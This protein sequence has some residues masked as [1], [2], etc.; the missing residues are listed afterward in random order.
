M[1]NYTDTR[2]PDH[3]AARPVESASASTACQTNDSKFCYVLTGTVLGL[4]ALLAIAITL[5]VFGAI[6]YMGTLSSSGY[7][8]DDVYNMPYGGHTY[9]YDYGYDYDYDNNWNWGGNTGVH[10]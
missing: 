1:N 6:G 7:D 2:Q 3:L 8:Y 5:L 4:V 10:A 9:D